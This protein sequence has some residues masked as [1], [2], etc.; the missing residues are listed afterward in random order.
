MSTKSSTP[1]RR[2]SFDT[3]LH[4][5]QVRLDEQREW[6]TGRKVGDMSPLPSAWEGANGK[7]ARLEDERRPDEPQQPPVQND[8]NPGPPYG[9]I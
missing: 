2:S 9:I 6:I 8:N 5:A 4:Q 7:L 1:G 3:A